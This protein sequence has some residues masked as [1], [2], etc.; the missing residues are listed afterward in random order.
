[1]KRTTILGTTFSHSTALQS[2]ISIEVRCE[3]EMFGDIA[4]MMELA[5]AGGR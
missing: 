5:V 4:A 2:N 1:M 3:I